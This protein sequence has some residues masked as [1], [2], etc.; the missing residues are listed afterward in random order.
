M[1]LFIKNSGTGA[2]ASVLFLPRQWSSTLPLA[3][4]G[5]NNSSDEQGSM[6]IE[7][8]PAL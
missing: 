2:K 8:N 4:A 7:K 1:Q 6:N 5:K 3:G